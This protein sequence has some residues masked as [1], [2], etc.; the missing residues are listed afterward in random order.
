MNDKKRKILIILLVL[1]GILIVGG[2]VGFSIFKNISFKDETNFILD[3]EIVLIVGD[4][5][6]LNTNS[7]DKDVEYKWSSSD[8]NIVIILDDGEIEAVGVG[9]AFIEVKYGDKTDKCKVVVKSINEAIQT[10]S[11][12]LKEK[13][14]SLK[15][16]DSYKLEY[17]ILPENATNKTVS[18]HSSNEDVVVIE[19]EKVKAIGSGDAVVSVVTADGNVDFCNIKVLKDENVKEEEKEE[20]DNKKIEVE[21]IDII[22]KDMTIN[23]DSYYHLRYTINPVNAETS[24]I[25]N[26]SDKKIVSISGDGLLIANGVGTATVTAHTLNGK[27]DSIKIT[28]IKPIVEVSSVSF[29]QE[30]IN[31]IVGEKF[32][33]VTNVNPSNATNK[34]LT[35]S[36]NND[37]V[38][39]SKTGD[40]NALKVGKAVVTVSTSNGK[41]DT[42]VVNVVEKEI[43]INSISIGKVKDTIEVG[44]KIQ[45]TEIYNPSNATRKNIKWT[46][47]NEKV[48]VVNEKGLVTAKG[49]G[50][51]TITAEVNNKTAIVNFNVIKSVSAISLN[52]STISININEKYDK[53]KVNVLPSDASVKKVTY[54][55]KNSGVATVDQNGV[56]KGIKKGKTEIVV[57][58]NNGKEAI[59]TV[60]VNEVALDKITLDTSDK[61]LSL[62]D[63]WK[64]NTILSP[65]NVTN[66]NV[67]WKSGTP[68]VA[69][70]NND[71]LVTAVGGGVSTITA[72]SNGKSVSIKV[73]VKNHNLILDNSE[74]LK[75]SG[76]NI[77]RGKTKVQL[78]GYN[79]GVY[80]SRSLAYMPVQP[81][82]SSM[83]EL[84][85]KGY[86]C[87]NSV[88]FIQALERNENIKAH[89]KQTGKSVSTVVQELSNILYNNYITEEDFDLIAQT[90]ANVIR[91][92]FEYE[93]F[94]YQNPK[95]G[96]Y[97]YSETRANVAFKRIDWVIEQ[98]K[99]RGIYVILDFHLAPGRQNSGGWC[100]KHMF[101]ENSNYQNASIYMWK[102]IAEE[103]KDEKAV[104]GYDILNEPEGPS[105]RIINFY[106]SVYDAIRSVD[107]NHIIFMEETCV[108]CGYSGVKR[109]DDIGSLPI[110]SSKGWTNVVYSTH[111]YFY[112]T[113]STDVSNDKN[114]AP[115]PDLIRDRFTD[116]T[117]KTIEKM[118][119]YQVPY[120]IGEFSH[121]GTT[122]NYDDY[123]KVW[124]EALDYYDKNGLSYTPWTYKGNHDRYYGLVYYGSKID[125]VNIETAYY[126][127]I[128][129]TFSTRSSNA[130]RF[131]KE[132]YQMF[133]QQWGGRLG[134]SI[135]MKCPT[136]SLKVGE[137]MTINY[138]VSP[139]KAIN[140]KVVWSSTKSDI[141]KIDPNTGKITALKKGKTTIKAT[142]NPLVLQ[143]ASK[144]VVAKCEIVVE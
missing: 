117:E 99:K 63:V 113:T 23:L 3:E 24:V 20:I 52:E 65:S 115:D 59:V 109:K 107:N 64:L 103:Y 47:D 144:S 86:S 140:K 11:I 72:T 84:K 14:K 136:S 101:F 81:I 93:L 73:T 13:E 53:L 34:E 50:K 133:L 19:N 55:S 74:F 100:G 125:R 70:V 7:K 35:Y 128:K 30:N 129:T 67:T 33:L 25:W 142:L 9:E 83:K 112:Q 108:L 95:N 44:E 37:V 49:K 139:S 54:T 39:V 43:P 69:T 97:S 123:L 91:L 77:V 56:I 27:K 92:P 116:K 18:Y 79:L 2:V 126:D 80:L 66:K 141:A 102:K 29:N 17:K 60:N 104:A 132:Y 61:V 106:D 62:G 51:V 28:V 48:A 8:E 111:D 22:N 5:I 68:S 130:M 76:I 119:D 10:E 143:D 98:C 71:G 4:K 137:N 40:V 57:K 120:Y 58:S 75:T 134:T 41:K 21:S 38:S 15:I 46:S 26:S 89:A 105:N 36:V 122:E 96:L 127:D 6:Y 1:F 45:L 16:G 135:D 90:G 12:T 85:S 32:K 124:N 87:I 121:Y 118:R 78:R 82:A 42:I 114:S 138:T 131:N 31:V 88:S 110:P 94:L